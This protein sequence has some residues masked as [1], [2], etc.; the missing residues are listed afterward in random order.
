MTEYK[1]RTISHDFEVLREM[2]DSEKFAEALSKRIW[3]MQ[4]EAEMVK[5]DQFDD[6]IRHGW[7]VYKLRT[8]LITTDG[9]IACRHT[10]A[11][12]LGR[13]ILDTLE[14]VYIENQFLDGQY[15]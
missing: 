13:A 2:I 15:E 14:Q 1:T 7:N 5:Y 11:M 12:H 6:E 8:T 4:Y 9:A 10:A 3:G